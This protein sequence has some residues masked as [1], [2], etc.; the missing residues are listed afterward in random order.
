M[1]G[2]TFIL[3][4]QLLPF[5]LAR[6]LQNQIITLVKGNGMFLHVFCFISLDK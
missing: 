1:M 5:R 4:Q 3:E 6:M 2:N